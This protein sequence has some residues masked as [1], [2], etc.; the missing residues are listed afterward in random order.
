MS[1]K[2]YRRKTKGSNYYVRFTCRGKQ[3]R[4][5]TGECTKP[6][7]KEVARAIFNKAHEERGQAAWFMKELLRMYLAFLRSG[8]DLVPVGYHNLFRLRLGSLKVKDVTAADIAGL[9]AEVAEDRE[10]KPATYNKYLGYL[11]AAFNYAIKMEKCNNNPCSKIPRRKETP[12][13]V[14]LTKEQVAEL[15]LLGPRDRE[16][17]CAILLSLATGIRAGELMQLKWS[18]IDFDSGF[19]TLHVRA[20]INKSNRARSIP[21]GEAVTQQLSELKDMRGSIK[22]FPGVTKYS[23]RELVERTRVHLGI[24]WTWHDLRHTFAVNCRRN[25]LD[26]QS[27]MRLLGHTSVT[28][29]QRYAEFG[30]DH[31]Y[32]R[33]S[34]PDF[35]RED[36]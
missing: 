20:E 6:A 35:A 11:S 30:D 33:A 25:G 5:T 18:D 15:L 23:I 17:S 34:M 9:L 31:D 19:G 32:M 8:A 29:T 13:E 7:A 36:K 1:Y 3:F 26:L 27:L 21:L 4:V 24:H 14:F 12:R 10:W 2:L 22:V 16:M 28:T